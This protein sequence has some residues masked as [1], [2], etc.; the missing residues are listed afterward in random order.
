MSVAVAVAVVA[1]AMAMVEG[2]AGLSRPWVQGMV[3]L[4]AKSCEFPALIL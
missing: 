2:E 1:I 3:R 4:R